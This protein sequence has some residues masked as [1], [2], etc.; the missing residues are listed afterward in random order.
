MSNVRVRFAPSP[1][2][3]FHIGSAR[4]ALFNWLYARTPGHVHPAD[5]GHPTRRATAETVS[6]VALPGSVFL[7][8]QDETV[9]R[10]AGI[11]PVER[12]VR[13]L[14]N[15]EE[16]R[17]A[18]RRNGHEMDMR[19]TGQLRKPRGVSKASPDS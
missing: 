7:D 12:A 5:R 8:P 1:T 14:P 13:A 6:A 15:M 17:G 9:P 2:G 10:C 16:A 4:T 18:G 11:K 3:F 19:E